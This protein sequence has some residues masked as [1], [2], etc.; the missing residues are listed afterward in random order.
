MLG[1]DRVAVKVAHRPMR[2]NFQRP[3][4]RNRQVLN[5]L[6]SILVAQPLPAAVRSERG[7][8]F[9]SGSVAVNPIDAE[10][11]VVVSV[12]EAGG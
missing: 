4:R 12:R 3:L 7:S 2:P 1:V 9:I 6:S 5:Q 11:T 8:L 10:A